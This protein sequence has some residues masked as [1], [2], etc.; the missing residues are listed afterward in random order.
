MVRAAGASYHRSID[1]WHDTGHR[2][3]R[4]GY[5]YLTPRVSRSAFAAEAGG[6]HGPSRG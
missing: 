6:L 4:I 5:Y 2:T 3:R 1:A